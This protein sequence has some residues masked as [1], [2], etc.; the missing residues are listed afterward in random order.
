VI[1]EQARAPLVPEPVP[2]ARP[3]VPQSFARLRPLVNA[4]LRDAVG[5]LSPE[6]APVAAYHLGWR[7]AEGRESNGDGGKSIRPTIALLAAESLGARAAVAIPGA[8]AIELVHDFS[9]LHDDVMDG[10]RERRHRPTVWAV[11]GPARAIVVG[12]A[13]LALAGQILL[14]VRGPQGVAAAAELTGATAE[15][16]RGQAEDLAFESR[17]D[18]SVEECLGMTGRK[19][20]A[21]L[22]CAGA[23][24]AILCRAD[25]RAVDA[26]RGYGRHLGTAFQAVDDVL[27]I[28]GDPAVTG[29]PSGAD[30]R[31]GKKSLP[32]AHGLASAAGVSEELRRALSRGEPDEDGIAR[33]VGLLE[34]AASRAWTLELAER[35]LSLALDCLDRA[36]LRPDAV[37]ALT[38]V[39]TF[40]VGRDY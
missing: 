24:G 2:N 11:F 9:L 19:T 30:L 5:R 4:G 15:M 8:V 36:G 10:D 25:R 35:H 13:L 3:P 28:W 16:I 27:G 18:V 34:E 22:S 33:M 17:P 7:D 12:D 1:R 21:L 32:V 20:G 26:M 14:E 23:L 37:A 40:V 6:L 31:A 38:E 29:K 39:A